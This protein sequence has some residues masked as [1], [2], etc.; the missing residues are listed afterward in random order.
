MLFFRVFFCFLDF[1]LSISFTFYL[2]I[3]F[4]ILLQVFKKNSKFVCKDRQL[5]TCGHGKQA[6]KRDQIR[7]F[8]LFYHKLIQ[9]K[10]STRTRSKHQ[11]S[12]NSLSGLVICQINC[13]TILFPFLDQSLSDFLNLNFSTFYRL[14]LK[15]YIKFYLKFYLKFCIKFC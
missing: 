8:L 1:F 7:L 3:S 12:M 15:F 9:Y 4:K 10:L 13:V 14:D 11:S 6:K 2:P 5:D